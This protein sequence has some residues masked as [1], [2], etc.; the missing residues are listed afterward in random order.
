M[1]L[2][3]ENAEFLDEGTG[4]SRTEVFETLFHSTHLKTNPPIFEELNAL[5]QEVDL[6]QTIRISEVRVLEQSEDKIDLIVRCPDL[7]VGT[8]TSR[9]DHPYL[10]FRGEDYTHYRMGIET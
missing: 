3:Y 5:K 4:L 6:P 7:T 10:V 1:E 2:N 8:Q 9:G